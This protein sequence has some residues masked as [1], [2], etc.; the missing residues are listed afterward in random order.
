M[1]SNNV[2]EFYRKFQSDGAQ[3]QTGRII[4]VGA[5]SCVVE[6]NGRNLNCVIMDSVTGLAIGKNVAVLIQGGSGFI[7]GTISNAN[8]G[9]GTTTVNGTTQAASTNSSATG[10]RQNV[11]YHTKPGHMYE[12]KQNIADTS[13]SILNLDQPTYRA[14]SS[15]EIVYGIGKYYKNYTFVSFPPKFITALRDNKSL[16]VTSVQVGILGA[17][18]YLLKRHG[19]AALPQY[20]DVRNTTCIVANGYS[21]VASYYID[22]S[23]S[24]TAENKKGLSAQDLRSSW[25][26]SYG[27]K[28]ETVWVDI[29]VSWLQYWMTNGGGGLVV[30]NADIVGW[31]QDKM[32]S[33]GGKPGN[34]TLRISGYT[35]A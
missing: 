22:Q 2:L 21:H 27:A 5:T 35:T 20:K 33:V 19:L 14:G 24:L 3:V 11:K 16:T 32:I 31:P 29:P 28:V 10:M 18:S 23:V 9:G 17:G 6:V 34:F 13:E 12:V 7:A 30:A 26:S 4:S 15:H 25:T 8:C 1:A